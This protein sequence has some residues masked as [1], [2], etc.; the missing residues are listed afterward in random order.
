MFSKTKK[1]YKPLKLP[2]YGLGTY[3][4]LA[5]LE[6]ITGLCILLS[7]IALYYAL[8]YFGVSGLLL[9]IPPLS[10]ALQWIL[11]DPEMAFFTVHGM[12]LS[13]CAAA[14]ATLKK[15]WEGLGQLIKT[16]LTVTAITGIL[17]LLIDRPRPNKLNNHSFPSG[18]TSAAFTGASYIHHRYGFKRAIPVYC[19]ASI[20]G[21]IRIQKE[22]HHP[23]DVLA[24]AGI[25]MVTAFNMIS[26]K[27]K[28]IP[29]KKVKVKSPQ[30]IKCK[31]K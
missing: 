4:L 23:T 19:A 14:Y 24:G 8:I 7:Q 29:P 6:E 21:L 12:A 17:K 9:T 30:K 13:F 27:P 16:Q 15:D 28:T 10:N 18:H 1:K 11:W 2:T 26:K 31:K 3:L 20:I 22:M 25:A 5:C